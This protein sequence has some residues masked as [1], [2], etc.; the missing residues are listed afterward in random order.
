M[1]LEKDILASFKNG[2]Y[3]II[4]VCAMRKQCQDIRRLAPPVILALKGLMPFPAVVH[5]VH[6]SNLFVIVILKSNN[7]CSYGGCCAKDS[8]GSRGSSRE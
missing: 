5:R 1:L 8:P 6:F 2:I 4:S 3:D 7:I